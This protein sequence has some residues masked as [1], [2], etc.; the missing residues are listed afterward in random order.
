ML[1]ILT[2]SK[3]CIVCNKG[4]TTGNN[5]SKS[6]RKTRRTFKANLQKIRISRKDTNIRAYVCTKCI[7][8]NKIKKAI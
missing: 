4:T 3:R 7:K 5:V 2:M 8:S 1:Y 6:H